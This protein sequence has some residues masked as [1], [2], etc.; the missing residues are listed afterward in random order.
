[1]PVPFVGVTGQP[2]VEA[3]LPGSQLV[4]GR[5]HTSLGGRRS[6]IHDDE[7]ALTVL[8]P[9][10]GEDVLVALVVRPPAA[11]ADAPLAVPEE[12][13]IGRFQHAPVEVC[14]VVIDG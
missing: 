4:P 11:L 6:I 8:D 9:A 5:M 1:V 7:R 3:P 12:I 13:P 10:P 2:I 14:E